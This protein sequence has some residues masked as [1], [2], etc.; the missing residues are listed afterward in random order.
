MGRLLDLAN[1]LTGAAV[2]PGSLTEISEGTATT[3]ASTGGSPGSLGSP[4]KTQ[5]REASA[6]RRER[7][8]NAGAIQSR[9]K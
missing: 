4:R 5:S 8:P 3:R 9:D 1:R 6:T 7:P 2:P